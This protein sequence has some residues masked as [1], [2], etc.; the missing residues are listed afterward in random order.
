MKTKSR[1]LWSYA[2]TLV[3]GLTFPSCCSDDEPNNDKPIVEEFKEETPKAR[4][5][6]ELTNAEKQLAGQSADFSIRLLQAANNTFTDNSQIVLSPLSASMALSMVGNGA[7]G[8]TQEEI[9]NTL[10]FNGFTAEDINLFNQKL[11]ATLPDL[12]NTSTVSIANSLWM[13]NGYTV[14]DAFEQSL[15]SGYDAEVRTEDF[16]NA[17]TVDLINEWCEA[18]TNGCIRDLIETLSPEC[19][20]V[21]MNALYFKGRWEEQFLSIK[22]K[23]FT[24]EEGFRQD[25]DYII[26]NRAH[27][28]Y[29]GSELFTMAELPYGN[30]AYSFVVVLPKEEVDINDCITGLTGEKW[31]EAVN[32]MEPT[33]INMELPK[34]KVKNQNSLSETLELM[35]MKKA[36]DLHADFSALSEQETFISDV[37]QANYLSVDENGTEAAAVT[38]V[39]MHGSNMSENEITPIDFHVN[40]PFLYFIKEKSTNTILFMGKIGQ[41]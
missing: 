31:L 40:R 23:A 27:Y 34:F 32:N 39:H 36:F 7:V 37:L 15:A 21:L 5:D 4:V 33:L 28:R 9:L 19:R 3:M 35:G 25:V 41:I 22:R 26:R 16:S 2:V 20:F 1:F 38:T 17:K 14:K 11:M 29:M 18:K 6:I 30:G 10:G 8:E 13:D 24:A 12:D